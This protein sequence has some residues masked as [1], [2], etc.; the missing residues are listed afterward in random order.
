MTRAYG[1]R[2]FCKIWDHVG[3]KND[4]DVTIGCEI[5][6]LRRAYKKQTF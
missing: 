3:E 5:I 1:S 6:V 4:S 2:Y